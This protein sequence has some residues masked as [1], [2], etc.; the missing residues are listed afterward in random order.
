M[1]IK[2]VTFS[3]DARSSILNGI[4]ILS[5]AVS[6]TLGAEGRTVIIED[7]SGYP[8]ITKDGVTVAKSIT[9][10]DPIENIGATLI[11]QA[12]SKTV[13]S[14]GDG[15]TTATVLASGIINRAMKEI[16]KGASPIWIKREIEDCSN[17]IFNELKNMAIPITKDKLFNVATISANNDV[18]LGSVIAEAFEKAGDNGM[19]VIESSENEKTYI[20]YVEGM[21]L[22]RGYES[23]YFI[24]DESKQRAILEKPLIL[25][26]DSKVDRIDDLIRF[27]EMASKSKRSLLILG[28]LDEKIVS[29]LA[30]NKIQNGFKVCVV[31]PAMF[32]DRKRQILQDLAIATG[33]IVLSDETGDNIDVVG[34]DALGEASKIIVSIDDTIVMLND[35]FK[36][37]IDDRVEGLKRRFEDSDNTI[38]KGYLKERISNLSG[39]VA[40]INVGAASEVELKEKKDRVDDAVNAVK[41]SMLE[42]IIT[43]GGIALLNISNKI[44]TDTVGGNILKESIKDPFKKI[45][46]NAGYDYNEYLKNT[47]KDGYGINVKTMKEVNMIEEGIIDPV[48]VTRKALENA[49]SVAGTIL[50]TDTVVSIARA[51]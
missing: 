22:K 48:K 36:A 50:L 51:K 3:N 17:F 41:A 31:K 37:E 30:M 49:I 15:T 9:L 34:F 35:D 45:L 43:G 32:G 21:S 8:Q 47:I 28:E 2:N 11:K 10:E 24:T 44:E 38:E 4:N 39:G 33:A 26:L 42:G 46:Q 18:A 27:I 12:A 40:I 19:V 25:I 23:H 16:D 7:I 5:D 13:D 29:V 20:D 1:N 6:S 14:V